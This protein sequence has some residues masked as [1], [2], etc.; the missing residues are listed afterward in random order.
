MPWFP[1]IDRECGLPG[2]GGSMDDEH[3]GPSPRCF[4]DTFAGAASSDQHL[5]A[6]RKLGWA[7]FG[8]RGNDRCSP[9]DR[10]VM[11]GMVACKKLLADGEQFAGH[12]DPEILTQGTLGVAVGDNGLSPASQ[13]VQ[14]KDEPRLHRF[15]QGVGLDFR[16]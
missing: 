6:P 14:G 9:Q 4:D 8:D 3:T 1:D 5:A 12:T 10:V 16:P 15:L 2:A 13:P 11:R 7:W